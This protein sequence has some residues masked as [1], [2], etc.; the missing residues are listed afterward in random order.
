M[1][2]A[3]TVPKT[4]N[5]PTVE[6]QLA[7]A[8]AEKAALQAQLDAEKAKRVREVYLK[9]SEKGGLS[10]YGIRRFPITFYVEEWIRILDMEPEIRS[11]LEA[12]QDKLS[13]KK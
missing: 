5:V 4:E 9:I 13:T 8:N 1:V 12:H 7:A 2:K 10:I 11:F 3:N 6:E